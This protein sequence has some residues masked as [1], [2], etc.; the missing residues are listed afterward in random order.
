MVMH[1]MDTI[2]KQMVVEH[3]MLILAEIL[4]IAFIIQLVI[5]HYMLIGH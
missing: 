3:Y 5:K 4:P 2:Q 1:L